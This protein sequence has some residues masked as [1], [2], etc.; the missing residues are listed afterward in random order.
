M[1]LAYHPVANVNP[2]Q[3][4]VYRR[5]AESGVGVLPLFDADDSMSLAAM[6]RLG[7]P[8][9]FHLHWTSWVLKGATSPQEAEARVDR[10]IEWLDR[11]SASGIALVW[12]IHN[13]L[14]HD[15]I[16]ES[17]QSR[18]QQW[19]AHH[20][21]VVHVMNAGTVSAA[22]HVMDVP[23]EKTL[24]VPHP[25]YVGAYPDL[26]SRDQARAILNLDPDEIV[27]VIAGALKAYKG[28]GR[29]I[30]ALDG[31][32]ANPP[33]RLLVV[34]KPDE[35]SEADA[36][37]RDCV[38]HSRV[39]ID[40]R[41]VP[42]SSMALYLRAADLAML[43]YER[44]LNSGAMLL[45]LS[46]GLPIIAPATG[47]MAEILTEDCAEIYDPATPVG[48][49]VALQKA[50][51]LLGGEAG[52]AARR[53]ADRFDADS[54][55]RQFAHGLRRRLTEAARNRDAAGGLLEQGMEH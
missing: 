44:T 3:T 7:V 53:L 47:A 52:A 38:Q 5:F 28:I 16:F 22:R 17:A 8:V 13:V 40:S 36:F 10:T 4:L 51:R 12:T 24:L 43:P 9:A 26:Y 34:G 37:V 39:L 41:T 55:S 42:D 23:V 50:D 1:L 25:S 30:P 2:Y 48:F 27:Y 21:D 20:A 19:L 29:L 45:A 18:L 33:R 11:L 32:G 46:F 14:P 35:S 31:L 15:V 54:L 49:E 6:A